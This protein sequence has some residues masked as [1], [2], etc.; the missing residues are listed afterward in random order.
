MLQELRDYWLPLML[1]AGTLLVAIVLL[2]LVALMPFVIEYVPLVPVLLLFADDATVR[3][4]SIVGAIGL[5]VTAFV[6]FRP[7]ASVLGRR[8]VK[9]PPGDTM[10]GA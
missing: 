9:K 4:S 8:S 10:A 3:R 7:N 2:L 6:F 5:I 1:F